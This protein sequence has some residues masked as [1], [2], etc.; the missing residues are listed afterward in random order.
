MQIQKLVT[1]YSKVISYC[2]SLFKCIVIIRSCKS[3]RQ[4]LLTFKQYK[5]LPY[6]DLSKQDVSEWR[7]AGMICVLARTFIVLDSKIYPDI[8]PLSWRYVEWSSY[9][10]SLT[11][12]RFD[13]NIDIR[14]DWV[15]C[16]ELIFTHLKMCLADAI[17]NFKWVKII[18]IWQYRGR[19]FSN[20]ADWCHILS[21]TCLKGGTYCANKKWKPPYMR[22]W[23]LKG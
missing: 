5:Q 8:G 10:L 22:H 11:V 23:R 19:L 21:L 20:I 15:S 2:V 6:F 7:G 18:Q 14:T 12:M 4:Y 3:K 16:L 13:K 17:H 1:A 9:K